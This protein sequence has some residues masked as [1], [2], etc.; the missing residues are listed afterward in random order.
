M[1]KSKQMLNSQMNYTLTLEFLKNYF[2]GHSKP[3]ISL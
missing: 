1:L 3:E 2:L